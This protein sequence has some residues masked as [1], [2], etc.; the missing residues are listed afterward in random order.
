M[1]LLAYFDLSSKLGCSNKPMEPVGVPKI[2][3]KF[4]T[5]RAVAI[6]LDFNGTLGDTAELM[7]AQRERLTQLFPD[8]PIAATLEAGHRLRSRFRDTHS[9][10][11]WS[12]R[13]EEWGRQY[14]GS[15]IHDQYSVAWVAAREILKLDESLIS[16]MSGDVDLALD[17][18]E[19]FG[20]ALY[21]EVP[22][23]LNRLK[24]IG[25]LAILT[26]GVN[27]HQLRKLAG[28]N[29]DLPSR[30]VGR[31]PEGGKARLVNEAWQPNERLFRLPLDGAVELVGG[32]FALIDD[33]LDNFENLVF[34]ADPEG[35]RAMGLFIDRR[36]KY[37]GK[38]LPPNVLRLATLSPTPELVRSFAITA[39]IPQAA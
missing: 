5:P 39:E 35:P 29:I 1:R 8:Y 30:V 2:M 16:D 15:S 17:D 9:G 4:E 21:S 11:S 24:K 3:T 23:V 37:A 22:E 33:S 34:D 13:D 38:T 12:K 31:L 7:A 25:S 10:Q 28:A 32:R 26:L 27:P 18:P 14:P 20:S 19:I 36:D 6:G